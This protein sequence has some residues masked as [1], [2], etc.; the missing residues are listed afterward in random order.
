MLI[1]EFKGI[2]IK[3]DEMEKIRVGFAAFMQFFGADV[4]PY[5]AF[6]R[7]NNVRHI[8]K[9]ATKPLEADLMQLTGVASIKW[10]ASSLESAQLEPKSAEWELEKPASKHSRQQK[11]SA[12]KKAK[13]CSGRQPKAP[14]ESRGAVSEPGCTAGEPVCAA[15][16]PV[17]AASEPM[18]AVGWEEALST[19]EFDMGLEELDLYDLLGSFDT[20]T[21]DAPHIALLP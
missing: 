20:T 16:E 9:Y 3:P 11:S 18:C 21:Q 4:V 5:G 10:D 7:N 17:C 1:V 6:V 8:T 12:R 19:A 2:S 15:S 14:A 13:V